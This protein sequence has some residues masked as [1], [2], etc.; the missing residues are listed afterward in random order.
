MRVRSACCAVDLAGA[1]VGVLL[2]RVPRR[3]GVAG[4]HLGGLRGQHMAMNV[5]GE[6]FAAGM[7]RPGKAPRDFRPRRQAFEQHLAPSSVSRILVR[8]S[9]V[10][11]AKSTGDRISRHASGIESAS[12]DA[13][14]CRLSKGWRMRTTVALDDELVEKHRPIPACA[15]NPRWSRGAQSVDRTRECAPAGAAGGSQPDLVQRRGGGSIRV[16]LVD[17]SVWVD[18][19]RVGD[20]ARPAARRGESSA[21]FV[22]GDSLSAISAT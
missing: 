7:R 10:L 11:I 19:L 16:I 8:S 1:L 12:N 2:A 4:D 22:T 9:P 20:R 17:T 6:P 13:I 3:G 18:H 21:S 5:D 14:I 15:R